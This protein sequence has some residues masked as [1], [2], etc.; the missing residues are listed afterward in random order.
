MFNKPTVTDKN[1]L[2]PTVII[3]GKTLRISKPTQKAA[4]FMAVTSTKNSIHLLIGGV[5][6]WNW[7]YRI[8]HFFPEK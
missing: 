1:P 5:I 8:F 4:T 7:F 2:K 6:S 3:F